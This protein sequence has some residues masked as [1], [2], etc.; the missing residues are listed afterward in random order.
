MEE[1]RVI[2]F[3]KNCLDLGAPNVE[4]KKFLDGESYVRIPALPQIATEQEVTLFHRAYPEQDSSLI[5]LFLMLK[6]LKRQ[7]DNISAVIPY[8]P[9]ARQDKMVLEGEAK[10]S[11]YVC[12]LLAECGLCE[13]ISFDVHFLKQKGTYRYGNL[14]IKNISLDEG[15]V[16]YF[17]KKCI[18]PLII[19][20]DKGAS[21][22]VSDKGGIAMEKKRKAYAQ[23]ELAIRRV[24]MMKTDADMK[25]R[26]VIIIDDMIAGGGTMIKAVELCR[27]KGAKRIFCGATHGLF[28]KDCAKKI[29]GA[30]A[31]EVISS[32]S[33]PSE[34]SKINLMDS[35]RGLL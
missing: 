29:I 5:Q 35:I 11:E 12:N 28:L 15:L 18:N 23:S 32:N 20:P 4:M 14:R 30:G 27:K 31:Q 34:Y 25:G 33:I 8:L 10:S 1:K 7:T 17:S 26:D 21:Y 22:M 16:K 3:S 6:T 2:F 9:Y 19:S 24:S 13:L